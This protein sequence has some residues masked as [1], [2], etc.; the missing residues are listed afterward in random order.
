MRRTTKKETPLAR[1]DRYIL[2]QLMVLFGF[3]ALVLVSVYWVNRAV[4]LFDRLIA[5]GH[6]A[7][8]FLEFTALSLPN[9]IGIVLPMAGFASAVYVTNRL[10]GDSELTV[11]QATGFS[12]WRI[13]RPVLIFGLVLMSMASI[14]S[15]VL[16]PVSSGQLDVRNRALSGNVS[17]RLLREGQFLHPTRGVTFYIGTIS[18]TGALYDVFLSDRRTPG[19]VTT[20][21]SVEAYLWNTDAGSHLVMM[22]GLAQTYQMDTQRLSTVTFKDL[23]YDISGFGVVK[24]R[25]TRRIGHIPTSEMIRDWPKVLGQT[26]LRDGPATEAFHSRFQQPLLSLVAALIGFSALMAAGFSRFGVGRQIVMAIFLL[27]FVK[28][29]ESAVTDPVRQNADLWMLVYVPSGVGFMISGGLLY[30]AARNFRRARPV[31]ASA[32]SGQEH[33]T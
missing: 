33:G 3:F 7:R 15:H 22:Q 26:G 32:I 31:R 8:V 5:D 25:E 17:A 4:R 30:H 1:F 2:S 21:T 16:I 23:T 10:I 11:M 19:R 24:E 14:L 12:P 6:S 18:E 13:A 29:V 27:V 28:L 9:V 20:Y